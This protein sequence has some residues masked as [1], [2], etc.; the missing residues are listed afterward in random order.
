MSDGIKEDFSLQDLKA[1]DR[2]EFA[3][4]VEA[5]SGH[6]Y[7]L[8]LKMLNNPQDAEDILQETFI[9]A[10]R[11]IDGFDGRSR[12]STWLYRIATNEALMLLRK[13]HPET[14]SI[15][16]TVDTAE[17]DIEPVQIVDWCCLPESELLSSEGRSKLDQAVDSL[18]HNLR[19]VFLLRDIEGLSTKE[20]ADVLNMTET[21]VKT[22]LSRARLRLRED[23][24][25]Y[26]KEKMEGEKNG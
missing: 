1:G 24:S 6:I 11:H 8:G 15:H 26:Y 9:K 10:F 23:L 14:I 5:Y 22:R 20:T 3:R 25:S 4:L 18:P 17:G 13:R 19:V 7:R 21:A 2:A 16:E 12:I